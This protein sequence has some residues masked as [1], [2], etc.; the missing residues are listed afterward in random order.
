MV[1]SALVAS[2]PLMWAR[3]AA[4][5]TFELKPIG[6]D[7]AATPSEL[8]WLKRWD[9]SRNFGA[10]RVRDRK[11]TWAEPDGIRVGNFILSTSVDVVTTYSDNVFATAANPIG[12]TSVIV[13]PTFTLR[14][15]FKR[16]VLDVQ[17]VGRLESFAQQKLLDTAGG[18]ARVDGVLHIDHAHALS[19]VLGI[20]RSHESELSSN[21]LAAAAERTPVTHHHA[22]LALKRDGG[23]LHGS[24]GLQYDELHYGNVAALGGGIID[25]SFRDMQI[26]SADISAGY[27]VAP[28]L[29]WTARVKAL[30]QENRGQVGLDIDAWGLEATVGFRAQA[31]PLLRFHAVGGFGMRNYDSVNLKSAGLGLLEAGIEWLPTQTITVSGSVRR[32][33]DDGLTNAA[34]GA[35]SAQRIDNDARL[36]IDMELAR[37]LIFTVG[38]DYRLSQFVGQDRE[39]SV[40]G[41]HAGLNYA[42]SKNW[43]VALGYSY[44]RRNS[45]LNGFDLQ[46]NK[47]WAGFKFKY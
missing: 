29:I 22:A 11:P 28:S 19:A 36:K 46:E 16:H 38:G 31:S 10:L 2:F 26:Y 21:I 4:A 15:Q 12:D 17:V 40:L 7:R 42:L 34:P 30:R 44:A 24:V 3:H 33:F 41:A 8:E 25:Q 37:N 14:S 1:A 47:V 13:Q 32:A 35:V 5:G 27:R 43:D 23:R 18:A 9:A 6:S 20:S 45:T 39:D